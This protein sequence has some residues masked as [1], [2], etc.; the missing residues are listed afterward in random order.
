M[1]LY[2]CL[3]S[4][5]AILLAVPLLTSGPEYWLGIDWIDGR[6]LYS[7]DDAYRY[8][9]AKNA[10]RLDSIFAWNYTLPVA[11]GFDALLAQIAG[12]KLQPMRLAH[13]CVG[14]ATLVIV[15]RTSLRTGCGPYLA[16]ASVAI[17]GL[18]PVYV[19]LSSSFY[20]EGLAA[21]LIALAFLLL[22]SGKTTALAICIGLLPL[23]RPEGAIYVVLF[24]I[25][26]GLRRDVPGCALVVLPGLVYVGVIALLM[27]D[28]IAMISWRLE[29]RKIL[30][31][32]DEGISQ[33]VAP[34][35]LPNLI[36]ASLAL[37]PLFMP[38]WRRW[39]P[40]LAGPW[41]LI[42]IQ[43]AGI[44]R[45]VQGFELRYL[46][47]ALPVFA[48]AWAFPIRSLLDRYRATA[49]ARRT[50]TAFALL[51]AMLIVATHARQSDWIR[52][53]VAGEL[54]ATHLA[55]WDKSRNIDQR[56]PVF[57]SRPLR[58]FAERIDRIV[59]DNR[60]MATVFV[61]H[62]APL[63]FAE[64]L[65]E[66]PTTDVVLIPHNATVAAYSGGY[67]FGFS[68]RSLEHRYYRFRPGSPADSPAVLIVNDA[69]RDPFDFGTADDRRATTTVAANVQ[70]GRLKA[71][72]V[73]YSVS[74]SV[75]WAIGR[76]ED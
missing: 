14:V 65:A 17:M 72:A 71:Y 24:L 58:A 2:A 49:P 12:G 28:G 37:A 44:A 22:V 61:S 43:S 21:F 59:T 19:V 33:A 46:A 52:D 1:L 64:F 48:V 15:A 30:A 50:M 38:R 18:M 76:Q 67:F 56:A 20:A 74:E 53:A 6:K 69:G 25:W 63:Y 54:S 55:R 23:V 13:A 16:A 62:W 4:V 47:T 75:T 8:F 35:R 40:I 70:S 73:E 60:G 51:T 29:L 5:A 36:W 66:R 10:F 34:G 31:P 68:L 57:D 3:L 32:L 9:A 7:I 27:N 41:C 26:F 42:A 45:G 11:L 39:W